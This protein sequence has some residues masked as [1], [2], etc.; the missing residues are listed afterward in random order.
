MLPRLQRYDLTILYKKGKDLFLAD[1]LSQA[2]L[3]EVSNCDFV[4]EL[5]D[6]NHKEY[7]PVRSEQWQRIKHAASDDA[8]LDV[9]C[10]VI[11]QGWSASKS[12][13]PRCLIPYYDTRDELT[14]QGDLVFK[15]HQVVVPL[16]LHRKMMEAIHASH[17]GVDGCI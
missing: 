5:E 14:I 15:G 6:I 11:Q 13:L 16:C 4:H 7:L 8:V 1:T 10:T 2:L 9:L 3:P 17:I 12:E